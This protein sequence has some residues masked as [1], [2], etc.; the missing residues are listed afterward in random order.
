MSRFQKKPVII[1]AIQLTDAVLDAPHP[2]DLHFPGVVYDPVNRCA[3]IKTLEGEM[4]ANL[5]DWIIKGVAGEVYPCKPEIFQATYEMVE[6]TTDTLPPL[7][8]RCPD[9]FCTIKGD[10]VHNGVR[11]SQHA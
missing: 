10:H 3:T 5:G 11:Y 6:E 9:C 2:S 8:G 1:E 7:G 4:R